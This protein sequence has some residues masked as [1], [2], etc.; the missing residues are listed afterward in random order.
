MSH[1]SLHHDI[2]PV[3]D[4]TRANDQSAAANSATDAA[5][6]PRRCPA[7]ASGL[8]CLLAIARS[9]G[10]AAD[11]GQLMHEFGDHAGADRKSVV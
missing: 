8:A 2:A 10:I 5:E 9:H 6:E 1:A 7:S 4:H 3:V 11:A